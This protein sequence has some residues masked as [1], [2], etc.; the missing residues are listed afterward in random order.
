MGLYGARTAFAVVILSAFLL[1]FYIKEHNRLIELRI[2]VPKLEKEVFG[3]E[4]EKKSLQFTVEQFMS[5]SRLE[6]ISR[7]SQY[8]YLRQIEPQDTIYIK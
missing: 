7:R 4:A 3:L 2:R 6:E 1:L 8:S 5:P